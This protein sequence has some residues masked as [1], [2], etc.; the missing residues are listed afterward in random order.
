MNLVASTGHTHTHTTVLG[1]LD[2]VRDNPGE[3]VPEKTFTHLHPSWASII[4]YL[5]PPSITIHGIFPVQFTC[6]SLSQVFFGLP[7]GLAP[8]TSY[9]IHFF[10]QSLSPFHI[11][12]EPRG[13]ASPIFLCMLPVAMAQSSSDGIAIRYAILVLRLTS[14][15]HTMGPLSRVGHSTVWFT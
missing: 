6:H 13:R 15:F 10:T 1:S 9:S 14:C 4:P 12:Q 5:L 7:L 8:S 2:F 3:L 11:T